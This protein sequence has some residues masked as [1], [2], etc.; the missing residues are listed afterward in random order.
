[1]KTLFLANAALLLLLSA[2]G[3]GQPPAQ[4]PISGVGSPTSAACGTGYTYSAQ[5]GCMPQGNCPVGYGYVNGGCVVATAGYGTGYP[6]YGT[7][8]PYTPGYGSPYVAPGGGCPYGYVY[9]GGVGCV[10][11]T[12]NCPQG[13]YYSP[14][15]GCIL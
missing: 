12:Q 14:Q 7:G 9:Q 6:G 3:C 5:Y 13:Y 1:M 10:A 2:A 11:Q 4:M 15:Q 8:Y